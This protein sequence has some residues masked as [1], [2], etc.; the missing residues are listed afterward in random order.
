MFREEQQQ[1]HR[2]MHHALLGA[3][4][5]VSLSVPM[6]APAATAAN[7]LLL[8]QPGSVCH[9]LRRIRI[10]RFRKRAH[11]MDRRSQPMAIG[12]AKKTSVAQSDQQPAVTG[13]VTMSGEPIEQGVIE[14]HGGPEAKDKITVDIHDGRFSIPEGHLSPGQYRV[15]IR[16][17]P[18]PADVDQAQDIP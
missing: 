8:R 15:E 12:P 9:L 18:D 14:F 17:V 7:R 10:R 1:S 11:H 6:S 13:T 3:F 16:S 5:F 2:R 4:V